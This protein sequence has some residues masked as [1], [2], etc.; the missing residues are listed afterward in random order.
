MAKVKRI[1]LMPPA[2]SLSFAS[3]VPLLPATPDAPDD[4][5]SRGRVESLLRAR[6]LDRT[7]TS[8]RPADDPNAPRMFWDV[9]A[10]DR[11]LEGGLKRGE[12]S[13]I[14]GPVSSGRTTLAWRWLAAASARGELVALVDTFDRFDPASGAACGMDLSRL[15]WAR[16]Q[17]LSKVGAAVDP[18]WLPG[19]RAVSGPGTLLERTIDRA[20]KALNLV[21][22]SQVCTA[23]VLDLADAPVSALRS[24][25]AS[26]WLRVQRVIEGSAT[27]CVLMAPVPTA[28]S[29]GGLTI[30]MGARDAQRGARAIWTD[31]HDRAR[32]F[33]GL[34]LDARLIAPRRAAV[35]NVALTAPMSPAL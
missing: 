18:A 21:L 32:R 11:A 10:L 8:A 4:A 34:R 16:G 28:R 33:G 9:A 23:V 12:L 29:A 31:A 27:A 20:L 5:G 30:D 22:Q 6:K 1:T 7:L 14:V 17:A 15:L 24:I 25:P 26:T 35:T 19:V 2:A 3:A 13:E